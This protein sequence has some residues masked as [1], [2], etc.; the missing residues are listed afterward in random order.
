MRSINKNINLEYNF[1]NFKPLFLKIL[2]QEIT[3]RKIKIF[4]FLAGA[5]VIFCCFYFFQ[6][7]DLE[8]NQINYGFR[9]INIKHKKTNLE[10]WQTYRN[11]KYGFEIRYPGNFSD[12]FSPI[13]TSEAVEFIDRDFLKN[14]DTDVNKLVGFIVFINSCENEKCISGHTSPVVMG[15]KTYKYIDSETAMIADKKFI[16]KNY[17][18]ILPNDY[19]KPFKFSS[20]SI[21]EKNTYFV[22]LHNFK[23][24]VNPEGHEK[25]FEDIL[26]TLKF[27]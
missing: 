13:T 2:W 4:L 24:S 21:N 6:I 12:G 10:E 25:E 8:L 16:K 11:D 14:H 1:K 18:D 3:N 5:A 26:A 27:F 22:F 7:I 15:D 19:R 20:W 9:Q 17:I 23:I